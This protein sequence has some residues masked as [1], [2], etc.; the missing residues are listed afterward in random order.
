[1]TPS[2]GPQ[3]APYDT[4]RIRAQLRR[5]QERLIDLTRGNP[6][7]GLNR[8]RVS[9]LRISAT[10]G[11]ALFRR[12]V[13]EERSLKMPLVRRIS[14]TDSPALLA[15]EGEEAGPKLVVDPGDVEFDESPSDLMRRLRRIY[16]NARTTVE[17]RGVTTLYVTFGML[18]WEDPAL[19]ESESPLWM[20]PC[21]LESTGLTTA[22][23]LSMVDEET[24]L[25]PA[26]ELYVRERHKVTLPRLPEEPGEDDLARFLIS[27]TKAVEAQRW[28]V[29]PD[30]WLSTY[31]FESLVIYQDLKAM[32]D[33]AVING[34]IAAFSRARS[35]GAAPIGAGCAPPAPV[36]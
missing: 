26:L 3:A 36:A 34:V 23:K 7:L 12:M 29:T 2:A 21:K 19:G 24:Q 17:E 27:V 8:S 30:A 20:V 15:A 1:M 28:T 14:N 4:E 32:A 22:L 31:T 11:G 25:N 18:H 10:T 9:K 6:L 5:W 33:R 13:I 35:D 16:D